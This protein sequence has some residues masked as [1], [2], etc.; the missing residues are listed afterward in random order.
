M[1]LQNWRIPEYFL[2]T[3]APSDCVLYAEALFASSLA[4]Q[5]GLKLL[6]P[7]ED[8]LVRLPYEYRK[9]E[10]TLSTLAHARLGTRVLFIKPPNDKSFPAA[11]YLGS[12]LPQEYA[13]ELSVLIAEVVQFELEFRCF[14]LD[15][16]L[17]SYSIYARFGESQEAQDFQSS[18]EENAQL[19]A[20]VAKILAD[21]RVDL[22]RAIVLDA[23][24][25]TA[26][27]WACVELNAAWGAGLYGCDPIGALQVIQA[28]VMAK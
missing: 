27:G 5:L 22:P 15:R 19:E 12:A 17:I 3:V 24:V 26:R 10:I 21:L 1:C 11:A 28:A 20:F 23:G 13:E 14:I 16:R 8:W 6:E 4:D 2:G 9:R 18:I 25:I 7:S